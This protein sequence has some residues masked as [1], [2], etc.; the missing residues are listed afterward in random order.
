MPLTGFQQELLLQSGDEEITEINLPRLRKKYSYEWENIDEDYLSNAFIW[1]DSRIDLNKIKKFNFWKNDFDLEKN[2]HFTDQKHIH[3]MD[4]DVC[5]PFLL[6]IENICGIIERGEKEDRGHYFKPT[7]L[8]QTGYL[9]DIYSK[10][11]DKMISELNVDYN[12]ISDRNKFQIPESAKKLPI[13][14]IVYLRNVILAFEKVETKTIRRRE[15]S[16]IVVRIIAGEILLN[17]N[18]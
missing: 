8:L 15:M 7:A 18:L 12:F 9:S 16:K 3:Y 11:E 10:I 4:K 14:Q 2:L 17:K 1:L 5:Y 6:E 13:N